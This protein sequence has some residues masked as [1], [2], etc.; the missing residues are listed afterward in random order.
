MIG[1]P[2]IMTKLNQLDAVLFD[3]DGTLIDTASDFIRVIKLMCDKYGH[4]VPSDTAIR[5]QVSA[6]S[7]ALVRLVLGDVLVDSL[8]DEK[9]LAYRQE[10]LD[11]YE[12]NICVDSRLFDDLD[13]LLR[14]LEHH[15]IAWGIVTNKPKYLAENLLDKLN[16]AE[17][18]AVLVCP[19]DVRNTKPDPE[20]MFLAVKRL[21]EKLS[22][23]TQPNNCIYVGDHIRDIQAGNAAGMMTVIAGFGY[24]SADDK[25]KLATWQADKV[26]ATPYDLVQFIKGLL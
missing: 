23:A 25:E 12:Q 26:M 13:E 10:F 18:C 16:L 4:L 19:D 3:L 6:G 9:L 20:P 7:R 5:E 2:K 1:K 24:L 11:L 21:N 17:R 22:K 8:G 14:T 15:G